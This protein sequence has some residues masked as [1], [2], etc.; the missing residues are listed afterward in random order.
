M[1]TTLQLFL[2]T[3]A[4]LYNLT[5]YDITLQRRDH[6]QLVVP[7]SAGRALTVLPS[8]EEGCREEMYGVPVIGRRCGGLSA[9]DPTLYEDGDVFLIRPDVGK[10]IEQMT[11][12]EFKESFCGG[13][14]MRFM[15][16][17]YADAVCCMVAAVHSGAFLRPS[18]SLPKLVEHLPKKS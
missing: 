15:S 3:S 18:S 6:V 10:V 4:K 8:L 9:F 16:P 7:P 14:D 17:V 2:R 1:S 11:E 12:V 5:N 13:R